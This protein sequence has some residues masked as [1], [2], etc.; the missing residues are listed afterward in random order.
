[1]PK[2]FGNLQELAMRDGRVAASLRDESTSNQ[3]VQF[4]VRE[5]SAKIKDQRCPFYLWNEH[6]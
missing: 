4:K 2:R 5:A 6:V 1:M 3:L